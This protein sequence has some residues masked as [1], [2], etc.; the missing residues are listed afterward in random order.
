MVAPQ[1]AAC[2]RSEKTG[3]PAFYQNQTTTAST[4]ATASAPVHKLFRK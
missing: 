2:M 1:A 4:T 3:E